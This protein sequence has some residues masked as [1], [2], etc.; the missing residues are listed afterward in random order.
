MKTR[1]I[2][3]VVMFLCCLSISGQQTKSAQVP[4]NNQ[5]ENILQLLN[6]NRELKKQIE[7]TRK[8]C[9]EDVKGKVAELDAEIG[10]WT[11]LIISIVT[12]LT[13]GLGVVLPLLINYFNNKQ[14][15]ERIDNATQQ[16]RIL[17]ESQNKKMLDIEQRMSE[18]LKL[19]EKT[20]KDAKIA[21]L[22]SQAFDEKDAWKAIDLYTQIIEIDSNAS[23]AYSN[24][25][26]WKDRMNDINGALLDYNKAI[27]LNPG[28]TQTYY[29]RGLIKRKL[30]DKISAIQDFDKAINLDPN[31]AEA[32]YNRAVSLLDLGKIDK[33]LEDA[34]IAIEKD[35][36][37]YYYYRTRGFIYIVKG[38]YQEAI[39]DCTL[40]FSLNNQDIKTQVYLQMSKEKLAKT[41]LGEK[42]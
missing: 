41:D 29:Y 4:A 26:V 22:S 20:A 30:N 9:R 42:K 5:Q 31:F 25:G 1:M 39:N 12:L 16:L 37:K 24:R 40:A 35:S 10:R 33:A 27:E 3:I 6:D 23:Q 18:E 19:A 21:Q 11:A 15:K 14:L 36:T 7:D 38:N 28:L 8:E 2:F 17:Y 34:T 32:Y 13:G